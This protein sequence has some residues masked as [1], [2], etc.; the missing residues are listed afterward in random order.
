M[1]TKVHAWKTAGVALPVLMSVSGA[2]AEESTVRKPNII[3]ILTDDQGFADLG[4]Q[5]IATDIR[6]PNLDRLAGQ[7][8]RL[9]MAIP[10]HRFAA[11]RGPG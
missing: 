9:R 11:L 5:G 3:V 10:P 8:A 7:G 2:F 4:V 6:T 1:K